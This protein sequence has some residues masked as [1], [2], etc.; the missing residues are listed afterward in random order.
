M[1][2]PSGTQIPQMMLGLSRWNGNFT[3]IFLLRSAR[4]VSASFPSHQESP[5]GSVKSVFPWAEA[6]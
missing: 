6:A 1:A 3:D 4:K 5:K 2:L